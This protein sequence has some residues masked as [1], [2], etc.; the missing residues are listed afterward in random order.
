MHVNSRTRHTSESDCEWYTERRREIRKQ[1]TGN[2]LL[3]MS[4][5]PHRVLE[6]QLIDVSSGGF[7]AWHYGAPLEVG[8]ELYFRYAS[9]AGLARVVWS[10]VESHRVVSGCCV[11]PPV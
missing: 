2:I 4:K 11:L 3:E 8:A 7:R 9:V 1:R 5:P 10:R 6:A